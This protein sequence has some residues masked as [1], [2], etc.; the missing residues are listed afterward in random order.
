M[1]NAFGKN[2]REE[3]T[4]EVEQTT[5]AQLGI[6]SPLYSQRCWLIY[7]KNWTRL[8]ILMVVNSALITNQDALTWEANENIIDLNKTST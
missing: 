3:R 2:A 4:E 7:L 5:R 1:K 8:I 6:R